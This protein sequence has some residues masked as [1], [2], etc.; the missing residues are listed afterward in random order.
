MAEQVGEIAAGATKPVRRGVQ[1]TLFAY[2]GQVHCSVKNACFAA[3]N[4]IA[5][6]RDWAVTLNEMIGDAML[7]R[8]RNAAVS[9]FMASTLTDLIMVDADNYCSAADFLRLLDHDVDVVGAACRSRSEPLKWPIRWQHQ[10][11]IERSSNGL[12]EVDSVGSGILRI[13]RKCIEAM[14]AARPDDWYV[15]ENVSARKSYALFEY[16]RSNNTW[17]GEDTTFCNR[18]RA[19]GGKVWIDPDIE[20]RHIGQ[21]EYTASVTAWLQTL[22]R[23]IELVSPESNKVSWVQNTLSS[24]PQ[25]VEADAPAMQAAE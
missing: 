13:S 5:N 14:I 10:P 23:K 9:L 8:A 21:V 7:P 1:L 24:Q 19:T 4:K 11:N 20:T 25:I 6:E 3:L 17:W 12:I 16:E 18:F 2:T 15:D 22:P